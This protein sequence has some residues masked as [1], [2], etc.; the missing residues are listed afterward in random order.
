MKLAK[1]FTDL[2]PVFDEADR[3]IM[4]FGERPKDFNVLQRSVTLSSIARGYIKLSGPDSRKFLQGQVTCDMQLVVDGQVIRGAHCT[5]KGRILFLFTAHCDTNDNIILETH[6]SITAQAIANLKKYAVFFK[7][8]ITDMSAALVTFLVAG[9]NCSDA[10]QGLST[11]PLPQPGA[12]LQEADFWLYCL[13]NERYSI[14]YTSPESAE[15]FIA[16]PRFTLTGE[17]YAALITLR[18]GFADITADTLDMFIPQMLNLDRQAFISFKKGCYTGQEIIARAHYR[19]AVKRRLRHIQ[20][21]LDKLPKPG[22]I[23]ADSNGRS[24]GSVASAAWCSASQ[25]ELLL[26]LADKVEALKGLQIGTQSNIDAREV[27]LP[28]PPLSKM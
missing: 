23:V 21:P 4:S 25:A 5:P 20:C 11:Q 7:T 19:G 1:L 13:A 27:E 12:H 2:N 8:E 3:R 16:S 10:L 26:V 28:Y 6:Q 18:S 15:K 24:V 17:T 22:E 14:T 9:P